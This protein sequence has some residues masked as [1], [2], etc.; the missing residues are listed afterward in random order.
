MTQIYHYFNIKT[1]N[2]SEIYEAIN[3]IRGIQGW[4]TSGT[5]KEGNQYA[6]S[7][8]GSITETFRITGD[9]PNESVEWTC[10]DGAEE[11]IGTVVEFKLIPKGDGTTDVSF[12]HYRWAEQ[13][14]F[15]AVCNYHW[16]L[17]LRSL[18]QYIETGE[19]TPHQF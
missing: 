19:G 4:W 8:A 9:I 1:S 7:F 17:Y 5:V 13:T 12:R 18:K 16:G 2:R 11:W 6:F 3:T 15:Y 14:S 10:V